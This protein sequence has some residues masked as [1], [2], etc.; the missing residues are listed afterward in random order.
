MRDHNFL[1]AS[2]PNVPIGGPVRVRLD[3]RLKHA[4]M[5]D[6]GDTINPTQQAAGFRTAAIEKIPLTSIF[7]SV[8]RSDGLL[9]GK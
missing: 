7:G 5:T 3:S 9:L 6:F 8:D 4:G 1:T 2:P